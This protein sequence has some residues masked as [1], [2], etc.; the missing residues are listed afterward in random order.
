MTK[1]AFYDPDFFNMPKPAAPPKPPVPPA[2]A[3]P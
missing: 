2:P 1:G 3:K